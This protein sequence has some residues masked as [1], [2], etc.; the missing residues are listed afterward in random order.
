LKKSLAFADEAR[1]VAV[2][3]VEVADET[4]GRADGRPSATAGGIVLVIAFPGELGAG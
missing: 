3:D 4:T 2:V 1:V